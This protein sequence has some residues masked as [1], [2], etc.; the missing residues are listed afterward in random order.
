MITGAN[1]G[2]GLEFAREYAAAGLDASLPRIGGPQP[3]KTLTDLAA[4]YPKVRIETLD[5]TNLDQARSWPR[6]SRAC[7]SMC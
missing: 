3:P 2:I 1:S 5:V 7:P 4:K 6:N